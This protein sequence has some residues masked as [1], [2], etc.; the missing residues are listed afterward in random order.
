VTE[1]ATGPDAFIQDLRDLGLDVAVR[2]GIAVFPYTISLGS[3]IGE[4]IQLGLQIPGDWPLSP[5]PGPHVS[6]P[7]QHPDGQVHPSP[8]G[9]DW[10]YWSRP[11]H[12]WAQTNRTAEDYMA[13]IRALF[14]KV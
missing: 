2:G 3:R 11:A 12:H 10:R 5:P 14:D 9:D 8:L 13:H 7:I 4:Q 6:P 1:H